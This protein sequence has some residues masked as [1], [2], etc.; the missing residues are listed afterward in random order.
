MKRVLFS[1]LGVT[2]PIKFNYDGP[3][4][5]I[6]RNYKPDEVYLFFTK[7]IAIIE[8]T[9]QR[10]TKSISM[11]GYKGTVHLIKSDIEDPSDFD[12]FMT[13]YK[14][15]LGDIRSSNPDAEI[16]VNVSSGT[17]QMISALCL[18]IASSKSIYKAVQVKTPTKESNIKPREFDIDKEIND[19]K[20]NTT[21]SLRCNEPQILNF[22][23][24]IKKSEILSLIKKYDYNA[25]LEILDRSLFPDQNLFELLSHAK[26]RLNLQYEEATKFALSFNLLPEEGSEANDFIEFFYV[27]KI[28]QLKGELSDF[29]LKITPFMTELLKLYVKRYINLADIT[30]PKDQKGKIVYHFSRTKIAEYDS[31]LLEYLDSK[32][33]G[34]EG[35]D[36]FEEGFINTFALNH[37]LRYIAENSDL[38]VKE[39]NDINRIKN[40]FGSFTDIEVKVRNTTAHEMVSVTEV[41]IKQHANK[42]SDKVI[43]SIETLLELVFPDNFRKNYLVYDDINRLIESHL[44]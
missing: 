28:K 12:S 2:D 33:K 25:A 26:C 19:L 29:V 4:L 1:P 22:R 35:K 18:E 36:K 38:P 43:V 34:N 16:L 10:Y 8:E 41:L 27:M 15:I 30:E 37:I 7:E 14:K 3:M 9:D 40:I 5:H 31:K 11:T 42:S 32:C 44:E 23:K 39:F 20:D 17:P 13:R 21:N 6:I 24:T